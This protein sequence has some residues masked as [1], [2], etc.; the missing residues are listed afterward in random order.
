MS[1]VRSLRTPESSFPSWVKRGTGIRSTL[2]PSSRSDSN[3]LHEPIEYHRNLQKSGSEPRPAPL[4]DVR[5]NGNYRFQDLVTSR[6]S[7]RFLKL[8]RK[9]VHND[10]QLMRFLPHAEV[11]EILH[12]V[13]LLARSAQTPCKFDAGAVLLPPGCAG[14]RGREFHCDDA[15]AFNEEPDHAVAPAERRSG[16][17][18]KR[19]RPPVRRF[20]VNASCVS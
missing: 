3:S 8:L 20:H 18:L 11:L 13:T 4:S 9:C 1:R 19:Q 14:W 7:P 17:T 15:A 12:R 6:P 5:G 10:P 2:R 16:L